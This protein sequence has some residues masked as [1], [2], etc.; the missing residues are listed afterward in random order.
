MAAG[1]PTVTLNFAA[2]IRSLRRGIDQVTLLTGAMAGGAVAA[3]G[4]LAG[5]PALIGGIGIAVAAQNEQVKASFT[6]LKDHVNAQLTTMVAP[7]VP[8]LIGIADKARAA[9]DSLGP[10]FTSMF[11]TVAPMIDM[12]ADGLLMLVTNIMPGLKTALESSTPVVQAISTGLGNMGIALGEM[13]SRVAA[14]GPAMGDTMTRIFD[15]INWLLP[16]IGSIVALMAEWSGILI[17]LA[18][19]FGAFNII[20][21]LVQS[22][23]I[24]YNAILAAGRIAMMLW[25]G[26]QWLLNAAMSANPIALVVIAIAALVAAFIW[27]YNNV[28]GFRKVVNDTW[29]NVKSAFQNGVN[30]VKGI[31]SWF[32]ELPG[33]FRAWFGGAKDT[34]VAQIQGL[35][36]FL[37]SLPGRILGV[38][39]NLGGLLA[40]AGRSLIMGFWNGI[41]GAF[42]WVIGG[43]RNLMGSIRNLFPF[44]P[45]K[46]GPFS[47]KGYTSFSG[48]AL[49]TDFAKG[50]KSGTPDIMRATEGAL[51]AASGALS[52]Q[53]SMGTLQGSGSGANSNSSTQ[54]TFAGN[55]SDALAS[56]IMGL[57]RTGQ[58]QIRT[59]V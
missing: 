43:V 11:A 1:G 7:I 6:S 56:V 19:A 41:V 38:L 59:G 52:G 40:N 21:R 30:T 57:I 37:G 2:D 12:V 16:V 9:F 5:V 18:I 17:P 46:D 34:A 28:E 20:L 49:A 22:G 45:A 10:T 58:I 24:I 27:A 33:K 4:L 26:A 15:I 14:S 51:G 23:I 32:G 36:G 44:S 13:F 50:I 35:L 8:V 42:N 53:V 47:G 48:Q 31:L 39:G 3:A 29:N 54:V 55:T 25:A